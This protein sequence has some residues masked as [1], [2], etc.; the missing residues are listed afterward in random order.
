[1]RAVFFSKR[2]EPGVWT[3]CGRCRVDAKVET[4][5]MV[6]VMTGNQLLAHLCLDCLPQVT[7]AISELA[8]HSFPDLDDIGN[9]L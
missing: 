5:T 6:R 7:L 8:P 2:G 4:E 9:L 1:M 3:R